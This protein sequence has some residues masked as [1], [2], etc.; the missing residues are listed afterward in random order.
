[1]NKTL[2]SLL[3]SAVVASFALSAQAAPTFCSVDGSPNPDGLRFSDMTYEGSNANDCYGVVPGNLNDQNYTSG[4]P[5]TDATTW[6]NAEIGAVW[7]TT[8]QYLVSDGAGGGSTTGSFGGYDFTLTADTGTSGTWTLTVD[9]TTGLPIF[10][11]FIGV[12]KASDRFGLWFFDDVEVNAS[13]AGTWQISYVNQGGQ[14]PALSHLDLWVRLGEGPD[15]EEPPEQVPEPG[16]LALLG[17]GLF[18]LWALRR[19]QIR[20]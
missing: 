12:L 10:V 1:M 20:G 2:L 3:V 5:P 14:I 15:E 19:R 7:G 6:L 13:N 9:P 18:G 17:G 11:D 8:W 4:G 16:S